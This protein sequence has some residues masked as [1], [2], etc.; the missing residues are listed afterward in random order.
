ML[1]DEIRNK[2]KNIL[3]VIKGGVSDD[4]LIWGRIIVIPGRKWMYYNNRFPI[5]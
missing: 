3:P 5:R 2:V 1:S 4:K